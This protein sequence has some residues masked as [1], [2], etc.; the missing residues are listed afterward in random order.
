[1]VFERLFPEIISI[2]E[3]FFSFMVVKVIDSFHDSLIRKSA[4]SVVSF[5]IRQAE[6]VDEETIFDS[7]YWDVRR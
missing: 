2:F 3:K 1:V 7:C 5:K 4:I 6:D